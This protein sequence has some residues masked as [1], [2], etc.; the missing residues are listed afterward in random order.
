MNI[1]KFLFLK[2]IFLKT[3]WFNCQK[4]LLKIDNLNS[5]IDKY[6]RFCDDYLN[7]NI[8][9]FNKF[10][11]EKMIKEEELALKNVGRWILNKLLL[12]E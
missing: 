4:D 12:I 5:D 10:L 2:A 11:N 6:E 3:V 1:L 9:E 8:K 7:T